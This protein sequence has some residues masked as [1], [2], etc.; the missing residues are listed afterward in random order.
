[1]DAVCC[2][3]FMGETPKSEVYQEG[4]GGGIVTCLDNG[5]VRDDGW[6][7]TLDAVATHTLFVTA[8][9]S[10]FPVGSTPCVVDSFKT[11]RAWTVVAM[12]RRLRRSWSSSEFLRV[13]P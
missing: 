13:D 2:K 12:A 5:N 1:M 4:H 10:L 8:F 3:K 7:E 9:S 11:R 6:L